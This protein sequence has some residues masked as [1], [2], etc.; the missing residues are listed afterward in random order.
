MMTV[1]TMITILKLYCVTL[2]C[3]PH[4][5]YYPLGITDIWF[6][7]IIYIGAYYLFIYNLESTE[8]DHDS[9][10]SR[11]ARPCYSRGCSNHHGGSRTSKKVK[12]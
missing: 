1:F 12:N 10:I 11:S 4:I 2:S 9:H 8:H 5:F 3:T 7:L 6:I